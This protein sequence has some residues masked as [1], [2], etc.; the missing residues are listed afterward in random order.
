MEG[1]KWKVTVL[2]A[3]LVG[4]SLQVHFSGNCLSLVFSQSVSRFEL[5]GTDVEQVDP[6]AIGGYKSIRQQRISWY[7]WKK[8]QMELSLSSQASEGNGRHTKQKVTIK[9]ALA[10]WDCPEESS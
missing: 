7:R 5:R 1:E 9:A 2:S 3:T 10:S 4:S 8:G 6:Q